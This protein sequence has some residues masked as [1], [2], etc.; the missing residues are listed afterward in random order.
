MNRYYICDKS[1]VPVKFKIIHDKNDKIIVGQLKI[2]ANIP[3]QANLAIIKVRTILIPHCKDIDCITA[4]RTKQAPCCS[5]NCLN[6][7]Y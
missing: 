2:A 6:T 4:I 5:G 7:T 3:T 1:I